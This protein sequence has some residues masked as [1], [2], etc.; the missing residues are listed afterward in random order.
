MDY[1]DIAGHIAY[2]LMIIG[3]IFITKKKAYG[4]VL[5]VVG[6]VIWVLIGGFLS[7]SSII[8]WSGV[9]AAVDIWGYIKW[10]QTNENK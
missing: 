4:F 2:I 10:V 1:L 7:M 8:V 9:F 3:H 5:R 6:G